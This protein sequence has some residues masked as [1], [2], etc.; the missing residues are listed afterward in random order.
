MIAVR[1]LDELNF[2][3]LGVVF[4]QVSEELLVIASVICGIVVKARIMR[5]LTPTA[6]SECNTL[7]SIPMPLRV[8]A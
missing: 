1:Q 6:V 4:L 2:R 3:V 5:M 8:N 7:L